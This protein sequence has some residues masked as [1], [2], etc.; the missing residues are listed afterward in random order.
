[1][2]FDD[3]FIP[4][5]DRSKQYMLE[6]QKNGTNAEVVMMAIVVT[7]LPCKECHNRMGSLRPDRL[8]RYLCTSVSAWVC[9]TCKHERGMDV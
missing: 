6:M 5:G 1:M 8:L 4:N 3:G 2:A 7:A 9:H